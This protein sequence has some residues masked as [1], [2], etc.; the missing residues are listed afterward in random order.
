M[1]L[2]RNRDLSSSSSPGEEEHIMTEE[3]C[4]LPNFRRKREEQEEENKEGKN[5]EI[6]SE[7]ESQWR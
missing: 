7:E 6:Q 5:E 3:L 1:S 2:Q 4:H